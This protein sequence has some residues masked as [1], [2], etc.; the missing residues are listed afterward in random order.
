M[1]NVCRKMLQ[2]RC[3]LSLEQTSAEAMHVAMVNVWKPYDREVAQNP[4]TVLDCASL[5][6]EDVVTTLYSGAIPGGKGISQLW[7]RET[8]SWLYW[9]KMQIEEALVFK[10]MDTRPN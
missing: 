5:Q 1:G 10:Q 6:Q 7:E 3:G 4:L 9:P 8:H 2:K